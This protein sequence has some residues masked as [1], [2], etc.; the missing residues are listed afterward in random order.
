MTEISDTDLTQPSVVA[1]L[2]GEYHQSYLML[3]IAFHPDTNRIGDV[4]SPCAEQHWNLG[5][6]NPDFHDPADSVELQLPRSLADLC[7]SRKALALEYKERSVILSRPSLSCRCQING[8]ELDGEIILSNEQLKA[9]VTIFLAYRVLLLLREITGSHVNDPSPSFAPL[10][11]G[12]SPYMG[13]LKK[14]IASVAA[15]DHDVLIRGETGTGKELV[16]SAI[17]RYS[18][19]ARQRM[20]SVNMSAIPEALAPAALF[21]SAKGAYTGAEVAGAGYFEQAEGG[22]LFLDEIGDTLPEIQAQLLRALQQREIQRVGGPVQKI[23]LR[24]IAA[25]DANLEEGSDFKAALRHRLGSCV[26]V[27]QPLREHPED[28]GVLLWLFLQDYLEAS[29]KSQLLP[30]PDSDPL[31]VASWADLFHVFQR[32]SWPGNVRHLSNFAHQVALASDQR[33]IL[34]DNLRVQLQPNSVPVVTTGGK[35]RKSESVDEQEFL[36]AMAA[37]RYEPKSA[38]RILGISRTAVY[39]RIGDSKELRLASQISQTELQEMLSA[40]EGDLNRAALELR[41][42]RSGLRSRLRSFGKSEK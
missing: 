17:H 5:R 32:F 35:L 12:S 30:R 21:G 34:P 11:K 19:R 36:D 4:S 24:V 15:S 18:Q 23:D 13:E 10:L 8:L 37:A 2:D 22:I 27:L 9:G 31:E 3:T 6:N 33:L 26:I 25:T 28:I 20:V 7:I 14:Q 39:R 16:A 1:D 38:A 40:C 42:S 41:V 29:G